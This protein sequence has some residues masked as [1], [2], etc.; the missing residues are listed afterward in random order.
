[1][2]T[3]SIIC[4]LRYQ[5]FND[6]DAQSDFDKNFVTQKPFKF[7][8]SYLKYAL[9]VAKNRILGLAVKWAV[10]FSF[11]CLISGNWWSK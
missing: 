5:F 3:I 11:Y 10:T 7:T 6:L 9:A 1:M 2:S 4:T 8:H